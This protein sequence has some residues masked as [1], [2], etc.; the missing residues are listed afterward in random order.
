VGIRI[1]EL[2]KAGIIGFKKDWNTN[3]YF[4]INPDLSLLFGPKIVEK[5]NFYEVV[6]DIINS[7]E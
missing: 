6:K 7:T 3:Y 2:I 4:V 1:R 5:N